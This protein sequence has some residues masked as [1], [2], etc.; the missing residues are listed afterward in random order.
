MWELWNLEIGKNMSLGN[1]RGQYFLDF[2]AANHPI[3]FIALVLYLP[4]SG[5][6]AFP[7]IWVV[8]GGSSYTSIWPRARTH[9]TP[10]YL[11][12][13]L[14]QY[15]AARLDSLGVGSSSLFSSQGTTLCLPSF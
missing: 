5:S 14:T 8:S 12:C 9:G 2:T 7:M 4:S 15:G 6:T 13:Q 1:Q 11:L 3:T 10:C